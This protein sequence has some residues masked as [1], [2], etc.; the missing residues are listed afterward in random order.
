MRK[1]P[2]QSLPDTHV[3]EPLLELNSYAYVSSKHPLASSGV[4]SWQ[5][6]AKALWVNFNQPHSQEAF[7]VLFLNQ[8]LAPPRTPVLTT[9][10][11][12]IKS[13]ILS[14]GFV[15]LLPEQLMASETAAGL[16]V[17]LA[18]PGTPIARQ[19]G[20]ITL[21]GSSPRPLMELFAE[22]ARDVCAGIHV[23]R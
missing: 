3:L 10:I 16:T 14:R 23:M 6:V 8:N 11:A 4:V 5:D 13:M 20:L 18:I 19:A 15:G 9:S 7:K 22:H 12:L 21:Q 2:V 1:F 17:R